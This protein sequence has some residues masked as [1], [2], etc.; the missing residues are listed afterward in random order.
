MQ[1]NTLT[2]AAL[3][4]LL[5]GMATSCQKDSEMISSQELSQKSLAQETSI[6]FFKIDGEKHYRKFDSQEE[7][8]EFMRH[9]IHLTREGHIIIIESNEK[10]NYAPDDKREFETKDKTE[11]DKW[12]TE[13]Y[14]KGYDVEIDFD[15]ERGIFKG[16]AIPK[17]TRNITAISTE[18][19]SDS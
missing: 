5:V 16:T 11:I 15:E 18:R 13:M 1:K 8:E 12:A 17:E 3:S 10:P 4:L 19:D 9:L 2:V 14:D 7:R 6:L